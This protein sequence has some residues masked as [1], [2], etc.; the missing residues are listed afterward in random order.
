M[1]TTTTGPWAELVKDMAPVAGQAMTSLTEILAEAER[2]GYFGFARSGMGVVDKV[3]TSFS[4]EDV[5]AL[6][7]N[8]V[9]ILD[10][11]KQMTQPEVMAM[12]RRTVG[13]ARES[14]PAEPPTLF[15]LLKEMRR[16]EVRMGLARVISMLGS[17]GA[18][19]PAARR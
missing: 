7:E 19:P 17:V 10:T 1:T 13:V 2:R 8:I 18:D 15:G 11:I 6:G 12:L 14:E 3:V 4:E 5:D 16:P 9:L